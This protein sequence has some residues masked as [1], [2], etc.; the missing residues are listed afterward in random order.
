MSIAARALGARAKKGFTTEEIL[1]VAG[2]LVDLGCREVA[3]IGGEAYLRPDVFRIVEFLASHGLRVSMQTGGR[4]LHAERCKA[5]K[6][7]GLYGVGVSVDGPMRIHDKLR[8][9]LGSYTAA[10]KALENAREAGMVVTSN[11]QINRLN[12]KH[13]WELVEALWKKDVIA[14]QVA[15]TVP[16]GNAA[17]IRPEWILEPYMMVEVIDT[18]AA[19]QIEGVKRYDGTTREPFNIFC[20]NNIGYYGPRQTTL[21]SRPGGKES[22]WSG[23]KAGQYVIGIESDGTI[24]GCPSLPTA[25]Y[26]GGNVL[27]TDIGELWQ[28]SEAV[29]FTRD[30]TTDELWGFCKTCY[31]ADEC[32]AGCSWT[33]HCTLGKRGNNPFCYHRV[34]QLEKKGRARGLEAEGARAAEPVRLRV[35]RAGGRAAAGARDG[36]LRRRVRCS[37]SSRDVAIRSATWVWGGGA[38]RERW[39]CGGWLRP[40]SRSPSSRGTSWP[41]RRRTPRRPH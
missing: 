15:I 26:A 22:F 36:R 3:L 35:L 12:Y 4:A 25:P 10:M 34:K 39:W 14:W 24:K 41:C 6:A 29:R 5:L 16:M 20:G 17:E 31:Y 37:A 21:R 30:R 8:G 13:L 27:D 38:I 18:L 33:A 19:I 7:A 1:Q 40:A 11:A 23:C 32:H 2:R 28:T 9:N